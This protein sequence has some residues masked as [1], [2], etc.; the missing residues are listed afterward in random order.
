MK[1]GRVTHEVDNQSLI[2]TI[3]IDE[4]FDVKSKIIHPVGHKPV[5]IF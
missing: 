4:V 5:V 3:I 2:S 1:Q